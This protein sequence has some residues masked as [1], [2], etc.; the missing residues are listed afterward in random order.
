MGVE[1]ERRFLVQNEPPIN[2]EKS[3]HIIQCYLPQND[4]LDVWGEDC[5]DIE[6]LLLES[7][8]T[9]RLRIMDNVAFATIKGS[10]DGPKR[11]EFEKKVDYE[12]VKNIVNSKKFPCV[13]KQRIFL[14]VEDGLFWEIDLFEGENSGLIIAEIEIPDP[15]HPITVPN[16]IGKEITGEDGVWSNYS[17]AINPLSNRN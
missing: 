2:M 10:S 13:E 17:L 14:P 3:A 6:N 15:E 5:A 4:W 16:W 7:N 8:T 12:V 11:F 1:I 9:F